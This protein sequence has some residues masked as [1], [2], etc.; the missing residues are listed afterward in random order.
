M[1]AHVYDVVQLPDGSQLLDICAP[2]VPDDQCK[3]LLVSLR[4]DREDVGELSRYRNQNLKVR[5][6]VRSMHGR[7]G[8]VLSHLRQFSG[9]AE[10]FKPNPQLLHGFNGQTDQ[11]PVRDPNLR[12]SGRHRSFTDAREK[13]TIP[14]T[15]SQ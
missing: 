1:S 2:D 7:M 8:I 11:M 10:K 6:I 13:E 4:E 9:G 3:F 15:P 5:G 12:A 14:A